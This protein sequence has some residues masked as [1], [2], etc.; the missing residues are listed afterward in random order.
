M[1]YEFIPPQTAE[2]FRITRF[3]GSSR[4]AWSRRWLGRGGH[5]LGRGFASEFNAQLH[6]VIDLS[7]VGW[8]SIWSVGA[9]RGLR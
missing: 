8:I 2:S 7:F 6:G 9:A 5:L 4:F 3:R 1:T